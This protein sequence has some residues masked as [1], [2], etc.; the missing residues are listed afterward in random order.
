MVSCCEERFHEDSKFSSTP[1]S[2]ANAADVGLQT[3]GEL[4]SAQSG[5]H[6]DVSVRSDPVMTWNC[7]QKTVHSLLHIKGAIL[8]TANGISTL[9]SGFRKH[10]DNDTAKLKVDPGFYVTIG[11][12]AVYGTVLSVLALSQQLRK[13]VGTSDYYHNACDLGN[14]ATR[15]IGQYW[16][17]YW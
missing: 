3:M 14:G 17:L 12:W 8:L 16:W 13:P 10:H 9:Y 15:G 6:H 7:F 11:L 4:T 5:T 1:D 2:E